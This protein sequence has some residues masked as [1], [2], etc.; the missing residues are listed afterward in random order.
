MHKLHNLLCNWCNLK[1]NY[2]R[3]DV[4]GPSFLL[5]IILHLEKQLSDLIRREHSGFCVGSSIY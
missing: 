3:F 2:I 1:I 4:A 5:K